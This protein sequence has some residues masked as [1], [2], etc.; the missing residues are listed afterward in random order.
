[1]RSTISEE[2]KSIEVYTVIDIIYIN[3]QVLEE[4]SLNPK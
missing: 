2:T 1:M 4:N 3:K